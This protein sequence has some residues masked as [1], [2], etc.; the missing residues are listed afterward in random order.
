MHR[1]TF[2]TLPGQLFR[3]QAEADV[4]GPGGAA[5]HVAVWTGADEDQYD[6]LASAGGRGAGEAA[7]GTDIVGSN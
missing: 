1:F 7:G 5:G 6:R 3:C 4:S 2:S